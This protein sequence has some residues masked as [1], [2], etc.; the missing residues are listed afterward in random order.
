MPSG[1]QVNG[2]DLDSIFAALQPSMTP[3]AATA[4]KVA[5]VDLNARY[6]PLSYG[7]AAPAT[8]F[9]ISSGADLSTV[10][11][12]L[13]STSISV[14]TQPSAVSGVAAA[15][16]PSG[17][18]SSSAM[19][20]SVIGGSPPYTYTWHV[21]GGASALN[22]SSPTTRMTA[23]VNG[24]STLS[25]SAFCTIMDSVGHS[26]NTSSAAYTLQNT[27]PAGDVLSMVAG[28]NAAVF[29]GQPGFYR[30]GTAPN[31]EGSLSPGSLGDGAPVTAL[32]SN[33]SGLGANP[34]WWFI[35]IGPIAEFNAMN[36][37]TQGYLTRMI[38]SGPGIGTVDLSGPASTFT[39]N[40]TQLGSWAWG[41]G[42][43]AFTPGATY[44]VTVVRFNQ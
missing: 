42:L 32:M 28:T 39:A 3:A 25:G 41:P 13:G 37:V 34:G 8:G 16:T 6:A 38:V 7:A 33:N 40:G 12:A 5:G 31:W 29:P 11:A 19:T 18:V 23:T 21:S 35:D 2:V 20:C 30:Q 14:V 22:P 43:P 24:Q 15:G 9:K 27:S 10:F 44:S 26:I 36:P 1:Y 17:T 4:F